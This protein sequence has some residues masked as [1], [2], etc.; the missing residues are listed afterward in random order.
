MRVLGRSRLLRLHMRP[1]LALASKL[2]LERGPVMTPAPDR[3]GHR[4]HPAPPAAGTYRLD[5]R[6]IGLAHRPCSQLH[7]FLRLGDRRAP[8]NYRIAGVVVRP[9]GRDEDG[10]V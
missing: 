1:R 8:G 10:L 9:L 5:A 3:T 7:E 6:G 2:E 4:P